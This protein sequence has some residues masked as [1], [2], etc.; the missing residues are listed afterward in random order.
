MLSANAL[1]Y[2][3]C[4]ENASQPVSQIVA[5]AAAAVEPQLSPIVLNCLRIRQDHTEVS[6]CDLMHMG[7]S[8]KARSLVHI[9]FIFSPQV[10]VLFA[11][12]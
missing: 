8:S 9:R 10:A 3:P 1:G 11:R 7:N 4:P 6:P 2:P 5:E 12:S